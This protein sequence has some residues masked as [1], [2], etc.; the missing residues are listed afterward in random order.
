SGP[1]GSVDAGRRIELD[2]PMATPPPS[3]LPALVDRA[4]QMTEDRLAKAP[5][6]STHSMYSSIRNQLRFMKETIAAG[7]SASIEDKN[8]L[9]L[10]VIAVRE[11]EDS[12]PDYCD[13]LTNAAYLF[14]NR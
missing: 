14:K 4:L 3:E 1:G 10:H 7:K 13:A 5:A 6:G 12:D 8:R 2:R 9:T 11:F